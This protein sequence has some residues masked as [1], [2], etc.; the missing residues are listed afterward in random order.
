ML[1]AICFHATVTTAS[2]AVASGPESGDCVANEAKAESGARGMP[3]SESESI[4]C[5][6]NGGL[7]NL[8]RRGH[9]NVIDACVSVSVSVSVSE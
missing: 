6:A 3:P 2:R 1:F 4:T 7:E 8:S 9:H 5:V